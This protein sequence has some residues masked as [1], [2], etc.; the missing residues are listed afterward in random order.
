MIFHSN[1][2]NFCLCLPLKIN[3]FVLTK[4]REK[5][6]TF[7]FPCCETASARCKRSGHKG[8]QPF[9][10]HLNDYTQFFH[11]QRNVEVNKL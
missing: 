1:K 6:K 3:N 7:L 8:I 5:R 9:D 10:N 2:S 4:Q 11:S